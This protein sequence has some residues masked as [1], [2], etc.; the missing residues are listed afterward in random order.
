LAV[1][2]KL[3]G[4]LP[5]PLSL[6]FGSL[7]LLLFGFICHAVMSS[8]DDRVSFHVSRK[9]AC[10]FRPKWFKSLF[11]CFEFAFVVIRFSAVSLFIAG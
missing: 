2:L 7:L 1:F 3:F 9:C 8:H 4:F 5:S 10:F 11:P 6:L